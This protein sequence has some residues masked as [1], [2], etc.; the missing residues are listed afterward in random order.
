MPVGAGRFNRGSWTMFGSEYDI[1]L[2]LLIPVIGGVIGYLTNVVAV[3]M[4]FFPLDFVGIRPWFGWRGII[5][6]NAVPLARSTLRL[7]MKRLLSVKDLFETLR[8]EDF[9]NPAEERIREETRKAV[10]ALAMQHAGPMWSALAEDVQEQVHA[11]AYKEVRALTVNLVGDVMENVEKLIDIEAL[12]ISSVKEDKGLMNRLFLEV[13]EIEFK[14]IERSG[15]F[16]GF[17]FGLIQMVIWALYPAWWILP[18]AGFFVGY[19]TNWVA[20]KLIFEPAE[21]RVYLGVTVQG[22]FHR[23]KTAV[24]TEFGRIV[25]ESVFT[26]EKLFDSLTAPHAREQVLQM[27][28]VRGDEVLERYRKHPMATMML[29][30]QLIATAEAQIQERVDSELFREDGVLAGVTAQSERIR[31]QIRDRMSALDPESFDGVLRPAF[32]QDEWKLIVAGAAL[33]LGAGFV[34]LFYLFGKALTD[35]LI[36]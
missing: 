4:M 5:P 16:F 14:F 12:V 17:G 7:I 29:N 36:Q 34:Q 11:M 33:G 21:P 6:A 23:R 10:E 30:D 19:A 28:K 9:V 27:V 3:K 1:G 35:T 20:L 2:L 13:G 26:D 31:V 22:L 18:L 15:L 32:K 8:P 24:A 25:T